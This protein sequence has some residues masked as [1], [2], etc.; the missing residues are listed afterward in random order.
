MRPYLQLTKPRITLMVVLM[1]ALGFWMAGGRNSWLMFWT[2]L[3]TGLS[4]AAAGTL[5]QWL[6]IAEDSAMQRTRNRPL[7][8]GAVLPRNALIFGIALAISG[9]ALLAW[10]ANTPAAILAA[11][12]LVLYVMIYTPLKRIT[13]QSTWVGS[14]AGAIPPLIGWAAARGSLSAGA[15]VLFAIQFLW[16]IPHFLALFWLYREDYARA[17]FKVMPVVDPG[18]RMT[19]IQIAVHSMALLIATMM[20]V[21]LGL[22]GMAY[23]VLAFIVGV[24][25][26]LLGMRAS[27]TM[28]IVDSRRLFLGSLAY[29]PIVFV[30]LLCVQ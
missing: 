8:R 1:A 20:P 21:L 9:V 22:T 3:G 6:E 27:W 26:L 7:P 16:Q 14:A 23:A 5:N 13:P 28:S 17:G 12:T 29:L 4:S 18:G 11:L 2:L 30:L 10:Q 15:W 19:A 25:F 24:G